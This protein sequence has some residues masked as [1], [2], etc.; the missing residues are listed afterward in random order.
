M[1]S[2]L[3]STSSQSS[4]FT[5]SKPRTKA[6]MKG[7]EN[8]KVSIPTTGLD[9]Q[10]ALNRSP[11]P[12]GCKL[13]ALADIALG[14][15][16][17][18]AVG[19]MRS[20][21]T[22]ALSISGGG[23]LST[24]IQTPSPSPPS[25][26][27]PPP[28]IPPPEEPL[29]SASSLDN[30]ST[31]EKDT[32]PFII[33][34]SDDKF[35]QKSID[36]VPTI[37]TTATA[38]AT[39]VGSKKL[40][41]KNKKET[42]GN[43]LG[44]KQKKKVPK[45][46]QPIEKPTLEQRDIYDF[47][48]SHDDSMDVPIV[49]L[50]H[51]RTKISGPELTAAIQ[52]I[53]QRTDDLAEEN[54]QVPNEIDDSPI[55]VTAQQT[56]SNGNEDV[57]TVANSPASSYSDRDDFNYDSVSESESTASSEAKPE[58]STSRPASRISNRSAK[59]I[60]NLQKKCLIMGRI[61]KTAKKTEVASVAEKPA[62]RDQGVVV[63]KPIPKQ[64]LD[65]LFDSLRGNSCAA[66]GG[67]SAAASVTNLPSKKQSKSLANENKSAAA[68][69]SEQNASSSSSA[70]KTAAATLKQSSVKKDD[71]AA[72]RDA[73]RRS[74]KPREVANME[75]EWG[76]SM[77]QIIDLIGVGQRKT[78]RRCAANKQ[79][80]F[81]ETWSSD[82]YEEFHSTKD[83]IAL[84]QE[85]EVKARRAR[86]RSAKNSKKLS[87]N[88]SKADDDDADNDNDAN[89]D[90]ADASTNIENN[91][92][93]RN[94]PPTNVEMENKKM[95]ANKVPTISD[96][97]P[98]RKSNTL[99]NFKEN[100]K[101]EKDKKNKHAPPAAAQTTV[102]STGIQSKDD[103]MVERKK[104]AIRDENSSGEMLSSSSTA[105]CGPN[106][107]GAT[108]TTG[109][110]KKQ[111]LP[112]STTKPKKSTTFSGVADSDDTDIDSEW[113][114]SVKRSKIKNRRRTIAF[115]EDET[116]IQTNTAK[117]KRNKTP[118]PPS[119][120]KFDATSKMSSASSSSH[121]HHHHHPQ[122][123]QQQ[124][125]SLI[126]VGTTHKSS[127]TTK[128][129]G[130]DH[131]K[132]MSRRKR[133][134]SEMLYYWSSSSDEEFGRIKPREN[135]DDDNLEQHGWIVGDSHKKLVTLLAHAKGKKIEDC[136]VKEAIHKK[137]S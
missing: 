106:S 108:T 29:S 105:E 81:A 107:T 46:R 116:K 52:S 28:L 12:T 22:S 53:T 60:N 24:K 17:P 43:S 132:P 57:N 66:S 54:D 100:N 9:M 77:E 68:K 129:T 80:T 39:V 50:S 79:R 45:S 130:G 113:S 25:T 76:M 35:K 78:Q 84:I 75:A 109:G 123:Q 63:K 112:Q 59:S 49:A 133:M 89:N 20:P 98:R 93:S 51:S 21:S 73:A 23:D 64:E 36:Q 137:K 48:D 27:T 1:D 7:Y 42:T 85:A 2:P 87:D 91:E 6:A 65:K 14:N 19:L 58:P 11:N 3:H 18:H 31:E 88:Q 74:R 86:S 115:H 96:S 136:G 90:D 16:V 135:Y 128:S 30:E 103:S 10:Q 117:S 44:F 71:K 101:P 122:Q 134:A 69:T 118:P 99:Y 32:S 94:V 26:P 38:T 124:R 92:K 125:N 61:F 83:I 114:K 72:K 55:P 82:E 97:D 102:Q 127:A 70:T 56:S 41:A 110:N 40:M 121:H 120:R 126:C 8:F 62:V 95:S 67:T 5:V 47:E 34:E 4:T 33:N 15:D 111:H 13:A 119:S 37:T 131:H 104:K